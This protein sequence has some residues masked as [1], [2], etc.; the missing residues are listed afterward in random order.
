MRV[1][2]CVYAC[3]CMCVQVQRVELCWE[4][5]TRRHVLSSC[6]ANHF[7]FAKCCFC[8]GHFANCP[9]KHELQVKHINSRQNLMVSHFPIGTAVSCLRY[10]G[11][12][13]PSAL[14]HQRS[15][16]VMASG[17]GHVTS[18]L[19]HVTGRSPIA[20]LQH[21]TLLLL[22]CATSHNDM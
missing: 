10:L 5:A 22:Q 18:G 7:I 11:Q 9:P 2:V 21:A 12:K 15:S 6:E 14:F 8:E 3:V 20:V 1:Y 16:H 19:G 13:A 4:Q 17:S